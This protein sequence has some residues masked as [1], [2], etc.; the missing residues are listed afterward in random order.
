MA[1]QCLPGDPRYVIK[2]KV[3]IFTPKLERLQKAS[4]YPTKSY[5]K[6][7]KKRLLKILLLN[8]IERSYSV[9]RIEAE[10]CVGGKLSFKSKPLSRRILNRGNTQQI[11]KRMN[12]SKRN[13]SITGCLVLFRLSMRYRL[14]E[15][16][17]AL[18]LSRDLM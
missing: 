17:L 2:T 10:H 15:D 13:H 5:L 12:L 14:V 16:A 11:T 3:C 6:K 8:E 9:F 7:G 4:F 1:K 18:I